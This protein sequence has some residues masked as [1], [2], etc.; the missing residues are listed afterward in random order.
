MFK[1]PLRQTV[2][3]HLRLLL[4]AFILKFVSNV[5][6]LLQQMTSADVIFSDAF[7]LGALRVRLKEI[8]DTLESNQ[9]PRLSNCFHAQLN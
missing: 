2:W 3:T 9:A 4:F 7:F 5:R 1:K 8:M 6:Q